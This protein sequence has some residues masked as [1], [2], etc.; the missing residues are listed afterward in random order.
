MFWPLSGGRESVSDSVGVGPLRFIVG[1]RVRLQN[2]R[3][4]T[5]G[6]LMH[7]DMVKV[8]VTSTV[9]SNHYVLIL[10]LIFS[11]IS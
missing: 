11:H 4:G 7:P 8:K 9:P 1:V 3:P 2:Y 6:M 10:K 5:R